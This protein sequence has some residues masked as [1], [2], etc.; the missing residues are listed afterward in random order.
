MSLPD[1]REAFEQYRKENE[2]SANKFWDSL[3][4]EDKC[5]AFHIVVSKLCEGEVK[6][7]GSYRYVLYDIFEFGPDMY[8]RGMDCGFMSLHNSI[9][10]PFFPV[11]DSQCQKP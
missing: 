9:T 8:V 1:I 5:N 4:Y 6:V 11:G 2:E 7:Q 10:S 3:S